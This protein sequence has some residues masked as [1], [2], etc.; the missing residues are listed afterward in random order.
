MH[1]WSS[2][3]GA[4]HD[5]NPGT[6]FHSLFLFLLYCQVGPCGTHVTSIIGIGSSFKVK[7]ANTKPSFH[8][9]GSKEPSGKQQITNTTWHMLSLHTSLQLLIDIWNWNIVCFFLKRQNTIYINQ[10]QILVFFSQIKYSSLLDMKLKSR[11]MLKIYILLIIILLSVMKNDF[12]FWWFDEKVIII[13]F[14]FN[15]LNIF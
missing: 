6:L 3:A 14:S 7:W 9:I 2:K 11:A 5:L 12:S 4:M 1:W 15:F 13:I 10:A 8:L